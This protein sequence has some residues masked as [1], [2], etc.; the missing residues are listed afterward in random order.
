L[1][2]LDAAETLIAGYNGLIHNRPPLAKHPSVT[3]EK[4]FESLP[5]PGQKQ[6]SPKQPV[7]LEP[8]CPTFVS[9]IETAARL[10][11]GK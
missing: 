8:E 6:H 9:A 4:A 10:V 7:Q 5:K 1:F 11:V 2:T 3:E